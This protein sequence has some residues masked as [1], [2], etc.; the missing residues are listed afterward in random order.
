MTDN[1]EKFSAAKTTNSFDE[2]IINHSER[3]SALEERTR[4]LATKEDLEKLKTNMSKEINNQTWKII[5][6]VAALVSAVYYVA[7]H[8]TPISN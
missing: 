6:V 1:H 7:T 8:S 4:Y 5:S 3:L 2:R